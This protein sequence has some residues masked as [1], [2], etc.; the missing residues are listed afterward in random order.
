M[1]ASVAKYLSRYGHTNPHAA[2]SVNRSYTHGLVI[3]IYDE[4]ANCV[5]RV[6]SRYGQIPPDV[7]VIA[8]VNAP[9]NAPVSAVR[10]TQQVLTALS[11]HSNVLVL[12]YCTAD[13]LPHKEGVG[14]ARKIGT[15][16]A[17]ALYANGMLTNPWLFQTD[18]DAQLPLDYFQTFGGEGVR[19]FAHQHQATNAACNKLTKAAQ[20]YDQHMQHYVAGLQLAG[21]PY[22]YPSL[23]S[24]LAVHADSYAQ[25]RGYPRRNAGEDF[26]LL[27]KLAKVSEVKYLPQIELLLDARL[28]PRVPFG[29]GPALTKIVAQL[30]TDPDGRG[31]LSYHPQTFNLLHIALTYLQALAAA[32]HAMICNDPRVERILCT[33]NI[34]RVRDMLHQKYPTC[35]QRQTM[36]NHWFDAFRTLRFVHEARHFFP[37]QPL[38]ESVS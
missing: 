30:E 32:D 4:A 19:V 31:Y 11:E 17:L 24:C 16:T 15:D 2:Q 23:G 26:Y 3:P 6:F 37:D 21:S 33:L 27:N 14:L 36:L 7:L 20:L 29:T 38:I 34:H 8:V 28:S 10:R 1:S 13:H 12:D 5:D 22:A 25:V 18:A 9:D 35:T